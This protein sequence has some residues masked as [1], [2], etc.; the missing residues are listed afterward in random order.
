MK[1]QSDLQKGIEDR[2]LITDL[3][4]E[5]LEPFNISFI[6]PKTPTN[7]EY[8]LWQKESC[9]EIPFIFRFSSDSDTYIKM[10]SKLT[11]MDEYLKSLESHYI[12]WIHKVE[13]K[14]YTSCTLPISMKY[15][16]THFKWTKH[17][18]EGNENRI[19][20][21]YKP[22]SESYLKIDGSPDIFGVSF[23]N[24]L[25]KLFEE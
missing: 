24:S 14:I 13:G 20:C 12:L 10:P 15:L 17:N 22:K 7:L 18:T 1:R 4:N 16:T 21:E 25:V 3:I 19:S 11:P 9:K 8:V 2:K 23:I 6:K 5:L